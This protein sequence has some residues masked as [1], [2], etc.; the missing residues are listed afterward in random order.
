MASRTV[1]NNLRK[2]A[3]AWKKAYEDLLSWVENPPH[4][5]CAICG[6]HAFYE[7]SE[8]CEDHQPERE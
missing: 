3:A 5:V 2:E 1:I 6:E 7:I 4:P 8:R